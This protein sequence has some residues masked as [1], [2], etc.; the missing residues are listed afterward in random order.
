MT[1]DSHTAVVDND[2][3]NHLIDSKLDDERLLAVLNLVFGDM[4]LCAV[5][6]PLVYEK[7]L[8]LDNARILL[9]LRK[10]VLQKAEFA[11][12]FQDDPEKRTYYIYLTKELYRRLTGNALPADEE[13]VLQYWV[14]KSS[15]G[16][17]HSVSMCLVCQSGIFLS[18][19]GDSKRLK[20][21]IDQMAIGKI[22]VYNR[23]EF[24]EKHMQEG[25]N[26]LKRP[27]RR[28]LTHSL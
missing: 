6:H 24:F 10:E 28:A 11:D 7:E 15:L 23:K 13:A 26:K 8:M 9:L 5:I 18:D 20:M 14:R 22:D 12:I 27:E 1:P 4:G 25:M 3:I 21:Y 19:D 2:F 16:E 17:V